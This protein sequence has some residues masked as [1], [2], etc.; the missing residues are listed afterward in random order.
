MRVR[1][2]HNEIVT[3]FDEGENVNIETM[4]LP[5]TLTFRVQASW[6]DA[7]D[8]PAAAGHTFSG[9]ARHPQQHPTLGQEPTGEDAIRTTVTRHHRHR[10]S[11]P[12]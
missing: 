8:P 10:A 4:T 6:H 7:S 5:K 9:V 12:S 3:D 2:Y 1:L 11:R